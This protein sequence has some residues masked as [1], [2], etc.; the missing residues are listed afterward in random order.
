MTWEQI[1]PYKEQLVDMELKLM[2]DYHYP[3]W[4]I[5]RSYPE[6]RVNGLKEHLA[7][8]DTFFWGAWSGCELLGYSWD[9]VAP[10]IDK[11]RWI[12]RSVYFREDSQSKGLGTKSLLAAIAKA[13]EIGCDE[14]STEY[15]PQNEKMA[16]LLKKNGFEV[17]RIEVVKKLELL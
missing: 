7:D 5:P 17:S 9:Y 13:K 14:M 16:N 1:E 2:I 11:K 15:V 3:D 12:R 8:G 6:S 10:F 4:N